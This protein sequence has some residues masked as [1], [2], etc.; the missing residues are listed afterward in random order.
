MSF[1]PQ[2]PPRF[3]SLPRI[4]SGVFIYQSVERKCPKA[5]ARRAFTLLELLVAMAIT[6]VIIGLLLIMVQSTTELWQKNTGRAKSFAAA[7][8]AFE[9]MTRT[10]SA[11]TLN[12]YLDYYN[13][14]RESRAAGD[15]NFRPNIYGRQSDLHFITGNNLVANQQGGAA[16]FTV[17]FDFEVNTANRG[18][19]GQLNG[20]GYFVR[21]TS[22]ST[23]PPHITNNP[24]RYRLHQFLQPTTNLKVMNANFS[25][26]A[27]FESDVNATPPAN[28]Y[29][30]AA[31]I[32]AF[33][34]LPKLSDLEV[35]EPQ[36]PNASLSTDYS[37]N[38][39]V[40]WPSG[41]QPGTMHQ[42]PPI[43]TVIMVALDENSAKRVENGAP[44][45]TM[46]FDPATIF[47]ITSDL[48]ENLAT[49]AEELSDRNL[50]YRIFR[51]EIPLR[52]AKWSPN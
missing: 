32:V 28:I 31:N 47:S 42:L 46:G 16:F 5:L 29:P 35:P 24:P 6:A 52:T 11:S 50:N 23:L 15:L 40:I 45:T 17:P 39:R 36:D 38:T 25:G 19:G 9:S 14:A 4:N 2:R 26:N 41:S 7:R 34:V 43:V 12:T 44:L 8:A 49:I 37:Y 21:L 20:V 33:A 30:L 13:A 18:T 22:D 48:E 3:S 27:W 51:A 1:A 10:I